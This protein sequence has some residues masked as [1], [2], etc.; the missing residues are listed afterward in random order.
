MNRHGAQNRRAGSVLV[1][2]LAVVA[3]VTAL[4]ALSAA[5]ALSRASANVRASKTPELRM[6]AFS[7]VSDCAALINADTND[8]DC[9]AEAWATPQLP[10]GV[11]ASVT[12]ENSR[13]CFTEATREETTALFAGLANEETRPQALETAAA[14]MSWWEEQKAAD[15]NLVLS[16]AE[17][18]FGAPGA[19]EN[20]VASAIPFLTVT[21][22]GKININTAPAEVL[23]SIFEGAGADAEISAGLADKIVRMRNA[24]LYFERI[25]AESAAAILA[26]SGEESDAREHEILLR[27]S[28][29]FC[30][31]SKIFRITATASDGIEKYTVRCMFERKTSK[32]TG[33]AEW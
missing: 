28:S 13:I 33:W 30:A 3:A 16:A 17:E 1:F 2:V 5:A 18:L 20:T 22:D 12:P 9:L 4:A 26:A 25:D 32:R 11:T 15:S 8:F 21:G 14:L 7:A 23:R 6:R 27:T 24:G 29:R 31:S 10:E 19:D